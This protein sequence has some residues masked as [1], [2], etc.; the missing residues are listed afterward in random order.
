MMAQA[1]RDPL[2]LAC[3]AVE[4]QDAPSVG[5]LCIRCHSPGGWEEGRST[6]TGGGMLPGSRGTSRTA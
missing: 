6:D 2:F 5:D 1:A 3:L 4:E